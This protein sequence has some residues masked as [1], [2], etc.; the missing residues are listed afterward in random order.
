MQSLGYL[1][2]AVN[3]ISGYFWVGYGRLLS[4]PGGCKFIYIYPHAER[5]SLS[6]STISSCV[7]H[8]VTSDFIF[9]E[10][11]P[12]IHSEHSYQIVARKQRAV[13]NGSLALAA[14]R[15]IL[16]HVS[17]LQLLSFQDGIC[18]YP[19]NVPYPDGL[20]LFWSYSESSQTDIMKPFIWNYSSMVNQY[21]VSG[22]DALSFRTLAQRM[23]G[24]LKKVRL[25]T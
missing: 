6:N 19:C 9:C 2:T 4:Y 15:V 14:P 7:L 16:T 25:G 20:L 13:N 8:S 12:H 23:A 1:N 10:K 24:I 5:L 21:T 18:F 3:T 17:P 11:I 22:C